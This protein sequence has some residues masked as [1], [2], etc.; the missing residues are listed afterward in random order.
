MEIRKIGGLELRIVS[1]DYA[2]KMYTE[3]FV[4]SGGEWIA[5]IV[6][7]GDGYVAVVAG[8][9]L[10]YLG[11]GNGSESYGSPEEAVLALWEHRSN[12]MHDVKTR[13]YGTKTI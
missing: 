8:G 6:E 10:N 12:A 11:N 13:G 7:R 9:A 2:G 5:K 3:R 1:R 4:Y